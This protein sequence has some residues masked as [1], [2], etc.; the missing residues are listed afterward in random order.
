M[1]ILSAQ[2]AGA[3]AVQQADRG[4]HA[5]GQHGRGQEDLFRLPYPRPPQATPATQGRKV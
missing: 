3:V 2:D 4:V 5:A 1:F